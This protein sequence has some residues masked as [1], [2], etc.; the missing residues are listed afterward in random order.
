MLITITIIYSIPATTLCQL[1][2]KLLGLGVGRVGNSLKKL[3]KEFVK[4]QGKK[5]QHFSSFKA[6]QWPIKRGNAACII[7]TTPESEGLEEV[8][9]FIGHSLPEDHSPEEP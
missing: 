1:Q 7:G 6:S 9:D 2:Q 3:E 4:L 8:F 5:D